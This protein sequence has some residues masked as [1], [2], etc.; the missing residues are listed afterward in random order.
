MEG[1][2]DVGVPRGCSPPPYSPS[3]SLPA[4]WGAAAP[5]PQPQMEEGA[6]G[7]PLAQEPRGEWQ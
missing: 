6:G 1:E 7:D 5:I 2:G 4:L 3:L